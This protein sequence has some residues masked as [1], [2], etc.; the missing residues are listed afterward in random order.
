[1]NGDSGAQCDVASMTRTVEPD[2]SIDNLQ[3]CLQPGR[4]QW[5]ETTGRLFQLLADLEGTILGNPK[6]I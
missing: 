1:V 2:T 3:H 4:E 6:V 5:Q